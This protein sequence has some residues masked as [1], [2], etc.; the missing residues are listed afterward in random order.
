MIV[1]SAL[2]ALLRRDRI[3]ILAALIAVTLLAWVYVLH[4]AAAMSDMAGM[5][6]MPDMPGMRMDAGGMLSPVFGRWS[7]AHFVTMFAMWSVMMIGM[8]TPSVAP[9]IL[10]YVQVARRYASTR[11]FASAG[12]FAFGYLL[13]WIGFSLLATVTQWGLEQAALLSPMMTSTSHV[14]AGVLLLATGIYQWLPIKSSCLARCRAPLSFVMEHGGF[15]SSAPGSVRLGL[16]HGLYCVGCCWA[17]MLLLYVGGVMNLL[18][19]GGLMV[20]VLLEKLVPGARY[21]AK[22]SGVAAA[23]LGLWYLLR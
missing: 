23:A 2:A 4:L 10:L 3:I 12:W 8:M 19:I 15:Q 17:L 5:A 16:Q 11:P 21:F 14:F 13:A 22:G 6:G 9:M 1:E 7:A 18:W 20:L